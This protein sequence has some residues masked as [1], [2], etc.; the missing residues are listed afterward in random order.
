MGASH[1]TETTQDPFL[2]E[3][4]QDTLLSTAGK[5]LGMGNYT[6]LQR[7]QGIY[8]S[9]PQQSFLIKELSPKVTAV[10]VTSGIGMTISLGLAKKTFSQFQPSHFFICVAVVGQ[11]APREALSGPTTSI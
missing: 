6:A 7:W 5:L 2:V 10:S 3:Q 8:A 9:S 1:H 4:T 11:K